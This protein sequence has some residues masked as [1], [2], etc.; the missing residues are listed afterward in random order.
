MI[1]TCRHS[2]KIYQEK[3]QTWEADIIRTLATALCIQVSQKTKFTIGRMIILLSEKK[4]LEL[5]TCTYNT[6]VPRA[7][8]SYVL[9]TQHRLVQCLPRENLTTTLRK[10]M[11]LRRLYKSRDWSA[12]DKSTH[13]VLKAAG[14]VSQ[15]CRTHHV[16]TLNHNREIFYM[17]IVHSPVSYSTM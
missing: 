17:Y 9:Q 15:S 10:M 7:C 8:K 1:D 3:Q 13:I 5:P 14:I 12:A 16:A 4:Y 11:A 6:W 2:G